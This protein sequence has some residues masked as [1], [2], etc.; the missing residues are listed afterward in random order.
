MVLE[1]TTVLTEGG[2]PCLAFDYNYVKPL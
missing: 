1:F 2:V